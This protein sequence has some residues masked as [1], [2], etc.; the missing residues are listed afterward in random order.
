[1]NDANL[2]LDTNVF[3]SFLLRRQSER[4]RIF[5][6]DTD[7]VFYCPRFFVVELFKH[8]ERITQATELD[9]EEEVLECLHE[10]LAHIQFVEE[11]LIPIGAWMEARHLCRDIDPK[12]TPFVA[13]T[14]HLDGRLWSDDEELKIGLRAKGFDRFFAP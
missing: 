8:K 11:G 13:L 9:R 10:L 14:L 6:T 3:F 5:L 12:D 7:H 4:R 2:I 1:M